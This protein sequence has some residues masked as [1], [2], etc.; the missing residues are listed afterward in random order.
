LLESASDSDASALNAT[1]AEL[2]AAVLPTD[3]AFIAY[4]SGSTS[5]PKGVQLCHGDLIENN[6]NIGERMLITEQDRL[7][8]AISLFWGY[9]CANALMNI[10][11]HGACFVLQESFEPGEALR[12]IEEEKCTMFYGTANMAQ[13]MHEHP[14]RAGRDLST[15]RGGAAVLPAHRVRRAQPRAAHAPAVARATAWARRAG[16]PSAGRGRPIAAGRGSCA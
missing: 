8:L 13:A 14:D 11:T 15:L 7:W 6:F 9:G 10:L 2:A 5:M 3:I 12:L 16:A 4:T 1:I